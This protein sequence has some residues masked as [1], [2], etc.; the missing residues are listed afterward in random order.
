MPVSLLNK[1]NEVREIV[2]IYV[3]LF[4]I[5][6]LNLAMNFSIL[7]SFYVDNFI[8]YRV[9]FDLFMCIHVIICLLVLTAV[10]FKIN[11]ALFCNMLFCDW[12]SSAIKVCS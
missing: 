8:Q 7:L 12:T 6:Y 5:D 11:V 9:L 1:R 4:Y 3:M 2:I 10:F